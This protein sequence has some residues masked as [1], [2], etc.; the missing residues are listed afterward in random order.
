V[1]RKTPLILGVILVAFILA[2][3]TAIAGSLHSTSAVT[4]ADHVAG[5]HSAH[6]PATAIQHSGHTASTSC[7]PA[8]AIVDAECVT[9]LA[10]NTV[11]PDGDLHV[12]PDDVGAII[13][14]RDPQLRHAERCDVH[15][16]SGSAR[17]ALLQVYLN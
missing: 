15:T 12:V 1:N 2:H 7:D 4:G 9:A 14:L 17:R 3:D 11:R 10:A 13:L 6:A 5:I 8:P 16:I